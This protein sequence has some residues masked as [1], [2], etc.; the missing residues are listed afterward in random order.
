MRQEGAIIKNTTADDLTERIRVIYF[1]K[2]RNE[3]GDIING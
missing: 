3:R 2:N 1:E